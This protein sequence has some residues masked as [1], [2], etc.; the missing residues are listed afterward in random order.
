MKNKHDLSDIGSIIS[1][2]M[3]SSFMKIISSTSI[4]ILG[5]LNP[6]AGIA[7]KVG[8]NILHKYNNFKFALL[9]KG[10]SIGT[11]IENRL[12]ELYN[13]VNSN[14][15]NA[16]NVANLFRKTL[17]A[18]CPKVC[19]IYG[20]IL[21]NHMGNDTE[22]TQDELIVCRA[23]ENAT[24]RDLKNFKD[25]MEKY[26]EPTPNGKKI[27]FPDGF[28][29]LIEF[30]T[31]CDWGVYNRIFVSR[32]AEYKNCSIILGTNYYEAESASILKEYI[33]KA[34]SIWDY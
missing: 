27:I 1:N 23:L 16:I 13:Y 11:N 10:L 15:G 19:V 2:V 17:N 8:G 34:Y 30:T 31:T 21:A 7:A 24:E 20:L 6:I 32:N 4:D 33:N 25:I 26:I 29:N 12:D 5:I 9:L 22:F 14:K 18:E 3:D 28:A